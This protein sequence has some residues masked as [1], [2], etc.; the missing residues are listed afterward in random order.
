MGL[1]VGAAMMKPHLRSHV[2]EGLKC[3]LIPSSCSRQ[4]LLTHDCA[5]ARSSKMSVADPTPLHTSLN[6]CGSQG[7]KTLPCEIEVREC[8]LCGYNTIYQPALLLHHGD[9][10]LCDF[11][12]HRLC[13]AKCLE[14]LYNPFLSC[15]CCGKISK[16]T[17][18]Y[19]VF[20]NENYDVPW[21]CPTCQ[22]PID[23]ASTVVWKCWDDD[24]EDIWDALAKWTKENRDVIG[25]HRNS[26]MTRS[27]VALNEKVSNEDWMLMLQTPR[28]LEDFLR[29]RREE[30][31]ALEKAL[32]VEKKRRR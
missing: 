26:D 1:L 23:E 30:I 9:D 4:T 32:E 31:V 21:A 16:E 11:C 28:Q 19:I 13:Q 15:W 10:L 12:S 2:T 29:E 17:L 20:S 25:F 27:C 24:V 8:H 18:A 22:Y 14:V 6:S 3:L 7:V 5:S